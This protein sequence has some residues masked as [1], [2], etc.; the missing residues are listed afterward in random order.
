MHGD[1]R[2]HIV[3]K[4]RQHLFRHL[5]RCADVVQLWGSGMVDLRHLR[6]RHQ[7]LFEVGQ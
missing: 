5:L 6:A 3:G 1:Q 7:S 4:C 2:F